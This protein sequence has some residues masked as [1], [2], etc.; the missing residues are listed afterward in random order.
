MFDIL[1]IVLNCICI[2]I[3]SIL[4]CIH[5]YFNDELQEKEDDYVYT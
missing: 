3:K 2:K 5:S 4:Q 1:V